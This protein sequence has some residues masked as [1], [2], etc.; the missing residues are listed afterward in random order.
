MPAFM[1]GAVLARAGVSRLA[2]I[3]LLIGELPHAVG[4]AT[5]ARSTVTTA[6]CCTS[7]S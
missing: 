4:T 3:D 1:I 5:T 2:G 7:T 6:S